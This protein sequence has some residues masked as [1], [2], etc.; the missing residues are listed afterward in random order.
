MN[1]RIYLAVLAMTTLSGCAVLPSL[2][3]G[4]KA[5]PVVIKKEEVART[6]LNLP[7]P[8]SLQINAVSWFI[9]TPENAENVWQQLRDKEIDLVLFA[10]TDDGYEQLAVDFAKIRNFI[11]QQYQIIREYRRYY[12]PEKQS[13]SKDEKK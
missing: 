11:E 10:L 12:E 5:D 1:L 4:Q 3:L 8:D 13:N 6:P 2:G 9:I 7:M